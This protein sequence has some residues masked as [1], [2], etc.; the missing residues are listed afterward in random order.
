MITRVINKWCRNRKKS[1]AVNEKE[2]KE[3]EDEEEGREKK[4]QN[5]NNPHSHF[6]CKTSLCS[7]SGMALPV[8]SSLGWCW[9]PESVVVPL[10]ERI[11]F[12]LTSKHPCVMAEE[13]T[14]QSSPVHMSQYNPSLVETK[15][16]PADMRLLHSSLALW[17]SWS[18]MT[19]TGCIFKE[20]CHQFL[21]IQL[22]SKV[23]QLGM[24]QTQG[25]SQSFSYCI[26]ESGC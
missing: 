19:M 13:H 18:L 4:E 3:E 5:N 25:L 9:V 26:A 6:Q 10:P 15:S 1:P 8:I 11:V 2:A 22:L 21:W 16:G 12:V 23:S 20:C 14:G 17:T 24:N 7:F